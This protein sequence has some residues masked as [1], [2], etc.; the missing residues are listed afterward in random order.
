MG[1]LAFFANLATSKAISGASSDA[2]KIAV[3]PHIKA[4]NIFQAIF[5]IGVFAGTI[6]PTGPWG[7]L[8]VWQNLPTT[9]EFNELE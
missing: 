5:A 2:F 1:T 6:R 8:I 7:C 4:G 3:L 9:A